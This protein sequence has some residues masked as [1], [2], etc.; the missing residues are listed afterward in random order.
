MTSNDK[1]I[2]KR[3]ADLKIQA[4]L[5]GMEIDWD[6]LSLTEIIKHKAKPWLERWREKESGRDFTNIDNGF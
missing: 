1:Q 3:V 6:T 4:M 5:F 2:L